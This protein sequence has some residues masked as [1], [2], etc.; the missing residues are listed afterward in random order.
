MQR[1]VRLL[2]TAAMAASASVGMAVPA[3]TSAPASAAVASVNAI[4]LNGFEAD[5]VREIND[6]RRSRGLRTL[7]VVAGATDVARR[8]SWRLAGAQQLWHNPAIVSDLQRA[9]SAAWTEIEENVGVGPATQPHVLFQAY[10][11]SPEHRANILDRGARYLGV[12]TV[13][14]NG[15]AFNTLDFTDAYSFGYGSTRVPAAGLTMDSTLI[16]STVNVAQLEAGVDQRFASAQHG[17]VRASRLSFTGPSA[18]NDAAVTWL[19]HSGTRTGVGS[20]IMRDA[21]DLSDATHLDVQL[22]ARSPRGQSVPV[23][24][25]LR[26][27]FGRSVSL[28]WVRASSGVRWADFTL[29]AAARSFY[30]TLVLSV[31]GKAVANAGGRVRLATYDVRA[32]V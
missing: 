23:H 9:G 10:M 8:W 27:S 15:A 7:T 31:D 5:L 30:N 29:P 3:A 4:R 32:A 6:A 2:L 11:E 25:V 17:S 24:V 21:L 14:R 12:G 26:Q 20:V 28:G 1:T 19:T 22:S 16:R 13:E 18:G